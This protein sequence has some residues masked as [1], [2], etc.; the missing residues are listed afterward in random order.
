[1]AWTGD[2]RVFAIERVLKSGEFVIAT[3]KIFRA[4]FMLHRNDNVLERK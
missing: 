3:Q 4:H 2:H 1:M